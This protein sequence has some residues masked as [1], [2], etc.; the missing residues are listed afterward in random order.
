MAEAIDE[1]PDEAV[2]DDEGF[3]DDDAEV[4]ELP[5]LHAAAPRARPVAV[6]VRARI[7][8]FTISPK[9]LIFPV[10]FLFFWSGLGRPRGPAAVR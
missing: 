8:R 1:E 5:E 2:D 7:R 10:G 6:T 9:L 3:A 4:P